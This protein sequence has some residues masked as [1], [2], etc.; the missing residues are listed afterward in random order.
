MVLAKGSEGRF[1]YIQT[2][3]NIYARE[4]ESIAEPSAST[5]EVDSLD[6]NVLLVKW[7]SLLFEKSLSFISTNG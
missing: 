2:V 6:M 5:E 3:E 4:F 7:G 1:I